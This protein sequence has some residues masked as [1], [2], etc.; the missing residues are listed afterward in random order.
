M[1]QRSLIRLKTSTL[2]QIAA[3]TFLAGS[4]AIY[5]L[6]KSVQNKVRSSPH[7]KQAFE[8]ISNHDRL[9][10]ELGKPIQIGTVDLADRRRNYIDEKISEFRVPVSGPLSSG[11]INIMAH[12]Q[13]KDDEF[14][15]SQLLFEG[16]DGEFLLYKK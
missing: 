12:R 2:V 13:D 8:I 5:F 10:D 9:L 15:V 7:Y 6:Q 14:K 3:G 11:Y 4:S 16:L 1:A